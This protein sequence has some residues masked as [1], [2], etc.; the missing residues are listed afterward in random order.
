MDYTGKSVIEVFV[1]VPR[2]YWNAFIRIVVLGQQDANIV[3]SER[4]GTGLS[5]AATWK[6][7]PIPSTTAGD[8]V[9]IDDPQNEGDVCSALVGSAPV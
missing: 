1:F 8:P 2:R 4:P 6:A 9:R 7:S 5:R 3:S